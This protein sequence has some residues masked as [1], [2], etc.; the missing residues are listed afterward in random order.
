[1]PAFVAVPD[2][3]PLPTT[4]NRHGFSSHGEPA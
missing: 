4:A 3:A 2:T 1:M